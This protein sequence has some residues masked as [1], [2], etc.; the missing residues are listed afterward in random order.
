MPTKQ[1]IRYS[2][3]DPQGIVFNGNYARYWD[4]AATDWFEEHGF[5]G[6]ELGGI[7]TDLVTAR[8]EIDF[9]AAA[10][11]GDELETALEVER[12]GNTS[13]TVAF[14]SRRVSDGAV[15]AEGKGVYVFVDPEHFRPVEVPGAVKERLA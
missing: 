6:A 9:K 5:G 11:L 13:M 8:L 3:C 15:V 10:R 7:G 2:D 14:T 12:F 4:D 1:K